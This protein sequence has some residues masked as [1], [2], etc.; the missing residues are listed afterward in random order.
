MKKL[1]IIILFFICHLSKAA[2]I[3]GPANVRDTIKGNVILS[4]E[5]NQYVYAY[6]M[7]NNWHKVMLTA[8]VK[9]SDLLDNLTIK[10]N[11]N[12]YNSN[13]EIKGQTKSSIDISGLWQNTDTEDWIEVMIYGFTYKGN[14][15]PE[16]I[17][18]R[19]IEKAISSGTSSNLNQVIGLF[20]FNEY[21]V[22]NYYVYTVYD[23]EDPWLSA[24]FRMMIYFDSDKKI[25]GI[26]NKGRALNIANKLESKIDRNYR[27][28]YLNPLSENERKEFEEKMTRYFAGRD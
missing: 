17:L 24:D 21:K 22:D 4:V 5:D 23:A 8:F 14:I 13:Q 18:E 20:G 15:K 1:L 16:T 9:K 25:I 26:A 19:A 11:V 27:M 6:E 7:K 28:Q 12:L 3:D 10:P 2:N